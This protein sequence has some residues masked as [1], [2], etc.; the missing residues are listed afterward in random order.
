MK[1]NSKSQARTKADSEQKDEDIFVSQHSR[2]PNVIGRV[3]CL[4]GKHDWSGENENVCQRC[5]KIAVGLPKFVNPP[6]PP[7]KTT[8]SPL[9][10]AVAVEP[11]K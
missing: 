10:E 1:L 11:E 6:K 5:R 3:F 8:F 2:K 7:I 4:L 9:E